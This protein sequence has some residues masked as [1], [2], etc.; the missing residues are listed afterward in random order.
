MG[1]IITGDQ[2]IY[3]QNFQEIPEEIQNAIAIDIEGVAMAQGAFNFLKFLLYYNHT[4]N[5]L[6]S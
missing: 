4:R 2:F 3:H 5:I 1:L 6:Y